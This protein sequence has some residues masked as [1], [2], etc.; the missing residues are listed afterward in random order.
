MSK[1]KTKYICSSC[2]YESLKWLGKCPS[3]EN[4]NSFT[5]EYIETKQSARKKI[6]IEPN[7]VN[8]TTQTLNEDTRFKTNID[9][10]D[11]VL[12]GGL[13][14]GS[15]ILI[16]GDPGIGKSTLMMQAASRIN[17][18]I[19][20]VTGEES[21]NQ[22]NIRAKRL[23]VRSQNISVLTETDLDL[24]INAIEKYK[25]QIVIIDSIQTTYKPGL[26]N[27]PGTVTQIRE[28]TLEL[29]QI[30]K[31]QNCAVLL[32]GH[33]T[34]EGFIAGPKVLEHI[35][36]TVLQ[37]EGERSY[38]YRILRSLKNRFG[39]TNEIGIFE[40]HEDGLHEVI[41]P[42]QIFLGEHDKELT[43]S[44]VTS[45]IE[46]TRPILLEVQA[47]VTPSTFGNPQ[48][49]ATGFDYRRL[50]ILLA[51][52]EKRA[53]LR[54]SSQNVFINMAGGLRIDEPAVDLAVCCAVASSFTD[55]SVKKNT[56]VIGE[57]GLGGEVRSV[58]YIDKRIQE[59]KKLGFKRVVLPVNNLKNIK[60][61]FDLEIIGV[62]N[63]KSTIEKIIG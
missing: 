22:I 4:W 23:N 20:Y 59:V 55:K 26:E 47:L 50:S 9:E 31:K 34:K 37:F 2:G 41:N 14:L 38:S 13:V 17:D 7:L 3:C 45:S 19:L 58:G 42:S 24:I 40:M 35:V 21:V 61:K 18:K 49:V 43:G 29:M 1:A 12:G 10:L 48:R 6:N 30:A 27:T 25:P 62:D 32:V 52:L 8:L 56:V 28:C 33:V 51:V 63:V 16:G 39:S 11:R 54:L 57:V 15:V 60:A 46:G 53:N 5:E 36:D 44:I